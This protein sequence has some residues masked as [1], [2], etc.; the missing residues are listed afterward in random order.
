MKAAL[1]S[2]DNEN[3]IDK[4]VNISVALKKYE[5]AAKYLEQLLDIAPDF[6]SA[7]T[8]LAFMRFEIG[9]KEPFD[10]IIHNSPSKAPHASLFDNGKDSTDISH[11]SREKLLVRLN[12]IRENRVLFKNIKY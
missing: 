5:Q 7:R 4:L 3:I 12:E 1:I 2:E 6:P 11:Y 9:D 8:R 10:E